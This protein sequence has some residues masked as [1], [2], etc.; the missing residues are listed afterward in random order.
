MNVQKFTL[1][2]MKAWCE[3]L[4]KSEHTMMQIRDYNEY[5]W[6][7]IAFETDAFGG[8]YLDLHI[9]HN[10]RNA[11]YWLGDEKKYVTTTEEIC[12]LVHEEKEKMLKARDMKGLSEFINSEY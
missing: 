5:G 8:C 12:R 4:A 3:S 10:T 11:Y 6:T 7:G 9:E 2:E 1:D